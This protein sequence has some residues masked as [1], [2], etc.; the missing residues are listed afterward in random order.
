MPLRPITRDIPSIVEHMVDTLKGGVM[1]FLLA[2]H[3]NSDAVLFWSLYQEVV[4][5]PG[6]GKAGREHAEGSLRKWVHILEI[7]SAEKGEQLTI[8]S[9]SKSDLAGYPEWAAG[10]R[11]PG[12][13]W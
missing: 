7:L 5:E 12:H 1:Y 13:C 10:A 3:D 8:I 2:I 9:Y 4:A 11:C 6:N